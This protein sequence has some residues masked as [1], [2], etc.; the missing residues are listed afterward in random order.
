MKKYQNSS[1]IVDW[2]VKNMGLEMAKEFSKFVIP[3]YNRFWK[4]K[5]SYEEIPTLNQC[6]DFIDQQYDIYK[7]DN[8][9]QTNFNKS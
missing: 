4:L 3:K 1:Y 9:I 5:E 8:A 7:R 2:L 6:L